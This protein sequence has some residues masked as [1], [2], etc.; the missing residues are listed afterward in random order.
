MASVHF[1]VVD[2]ALDW[3]QAL[4]TGWIAGIVVGDSGL[5]EEPDYIAEVFAVGIELVVFD[6][7]VPAVALEEVVHIALAAVWY[8]ALRTDS[9]AHTA[10]AVALVIPDSFAHKPRDQ[11]LASCN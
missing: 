3:R 8:S 10:L 5:G 6:H 1:A 4:A 2:Q 11:A 7:I 9:A